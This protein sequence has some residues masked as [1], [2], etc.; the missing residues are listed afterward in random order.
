MRTLR[1]T[2]YNIQWWVGE[3][4]G[5]LWR[6]LVNSEQVS[7]KSS[8]E[9]GQWLRSWPRTSLKYLTYNWSFSL[10]TLHLHK[11]ITW[12][13]KTLMQL[14]VFFSPGN[15]PLTYVSFSHVLSETLWLYVVIQWRFS[16][17]PPNLASSKL[18]TPTSRKGERID[19]T[20]NMTMCHDVPA[21]WM[22]CTAIERGPV[23]A[24]PVTS[25]TLRWGGS[26]ALWLFNSGSLP[27]LA[28]LIRW[29]L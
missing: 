17:M 8:A 22:V 27:R 26:P 23:S 2:T 7:F 21:E 9:T 11:P 13:K 6:V 20:H 16:F 10:S 25:G 29:D 12:G 1:P 14:H 15:S 4:T 3:G 5:W 18:S 24:M 28:A 19:V